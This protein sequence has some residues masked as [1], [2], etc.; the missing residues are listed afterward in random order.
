MT[1]TFSLSELLAATQAKVFNRTAPGF[2]N[3]FDPA[4]LSTDARTLQ[5][6]QLFLPI[7]G[8]RFD[9]HDFRQQAYEAGAVGCFMQANHAVLPSQP[10]QLIVP[11]TL[12]AY[13]QLAR[14]HRR[15]VNPKV[16]GITGSS[17]KTTTKTLFQTAFQGVY[18][19][20]CTQKNFNNDIGVAQT[21]LALQP[22]TQLAVVEM[23]MRGPGEITRLTLAAEPDIA[24]ITNIGPAHIERLGS[25]EAIAQAKC[26][27]VKGLHP[28]RGVVVANGDDALLMHTLKQVWTG[29]LETFSL[30]QARH[31]AATPDG[32]VQFMTRGQTV[33][34]TVP[35][36]H[37]I[38]N[39]LSV[40]TVAQIL[41]IPLDDIAHGLSQFH[42]EEGRY[43]VKALPND[44]H[45]IQDA[46][47]ANPSSM[48]ASLTAFLQQPTPLPQQ[49]KALVL[50]GMNE[51]GDMSVHYHTVLGH[52]L[53]THGGPLAW[54]LLIGEDCL[55]TAQALGQALP[56][57]WVPN[58]DEARQWLA[59]QTLN[60]RFILVKGSRSYQLEQ[61]LTGQGVAPH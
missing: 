49:Q 18:R 60:S 47:N 59:Q 58:V 2:D 7:V 55:P 44:L 27:M 46:Y 3:P 30:T 39:A 15:R 51:L 57:H 23:A 4:S 54:V 11:D 19:T 40:I 25:L 43:S 35:G 36:N 22:D 8:D 10:N 41:G 50:A 45:V 31:I 26:E 24:I 29:R 20:Q 16:V 28:V 9:G 61:V 5:P 42:P 1:A 21:L 12:M 53:K 14:F 37:M 52:W 48:E 38:M 13:Q 33:T 6:G 17:G 34:L 32:G 56:V